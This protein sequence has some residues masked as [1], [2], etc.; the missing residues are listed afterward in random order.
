MFK[1]FSNTVPSYIES[2]L[3]SFTENPNYKI[4]SIFYNTCIFEG[5]LVHNVLL[6]YIIIPT[7]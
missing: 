3:N 4:I 5:E 7:E 1:F 2:D 6:Y